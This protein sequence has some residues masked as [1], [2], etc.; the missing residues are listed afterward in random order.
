MK[1]PLSGCDG[2]SDIGMETSIKKQHTNFHFLP[3]FLVDCGRHRHGHFQRLFKTV[4]EKALYMSSEGRNIFLLFTFCLSS[5]S[6]STLSFVPETILKFVKVLRIQ[7]WMLDRILFVSL[8]RKTRSGVSW[9][10]HLF[11]S[12]L[13]IRTLLFEKIFYSLSYLYW[14]HIKSQN[15][16]SQKIKNMKK[17]EEAR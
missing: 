13:L 2:S 3:N 4:L 15:K 16:R 17:N 9:S 8:K 14:K 1:L 10:I 12:S 5:S 6:S 11:S 7:L